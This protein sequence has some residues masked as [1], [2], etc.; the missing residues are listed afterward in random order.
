MGRWL[1]TQNRE[2][3]REGIFNWTLPAWAG[4][5]ADG[6]TYNTCP[7]AGVCRKAC[8]ALNGTYRFPVVKAAHEANLAMVL[9]DLPGWQRRMATELEHKRYQGRWVR[10]HD[11]GDFFSDAYLE[12]WLELI[13]D[14]EATDFYAYTKELDRFERLVAPDPPPNFGWVYS[15]GG[16]QDGQLDPARHRVADVFPD[17]A[18]I[19]AAGWHSQDSSD[20]LAVSGPAPVGIPQNNIPGFR[21]R[22]AGRTFREWQ[23]QEQAGGRQPQSAE[24]R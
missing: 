15:Y 21:K 24:H 11:A 10:I 3:R 17:E 12:A 4:R 6:R 23:Q 9:D 2:M 13:W 20:L 1:L 22:F 5:L 18:A 16:T 8:Y 7:S 14:A 19:E